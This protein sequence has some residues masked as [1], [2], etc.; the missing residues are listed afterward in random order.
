MTYVDAMRVLG[1]EGAPDSASVRRAYLARVKAHSPEKDP[2]GF[3]R[4]RS[5]F[6]LLRELVGVAAPAQT[7]EPVSG[8]MSID[9][10]DRTDPLLERPPP[11]DDPLDEVRARISACTDP[12]ER[13]RLGRE[14]AAVHR[15]AAAHWLWLES[16]DMEAGPDEAVQVAREALSHGH[17]EFL[18][19]LRAVHPS[20]LSDVELDAWLEEN[21][22]IPGGDALSLAWTLIDRR[23][24]HDASSVLQRLLDAG[25]G[26]LDPVATPGAILHL[27]LRLLE[28]GS[29]AEARG[30]VSALGARYGECPSAPGANP[31]VTQ[32]TIELAL[33]AEQ[34]DPALVKVI[35]SALAGHQPE[36]ADHVLRKVAAYDGPLARR[37]VAL[38]RT[39]APT[40]RGLY[41][42]PLKEGP[43]TVAEWVAS[44][45]RIRWPF[46]SAVAWGLY[47][48]VQ[49]VV[50][51]GHFTPA[52]TTAAARE[53]LAA[54]AVAHAPVAALCYGNESSDLCLAARS[55][56]AKRSCDDA[57][58]E[59]D[60]ISQLAERLSSHRAL[61]RT[62]QIAL[63]EIARRTRIQCSSTSTPASSQ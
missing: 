57:L 11:A 13:V 45:R 8:S 30:V 34:L 33:I 7:A 2:E 52:R 12:W 40:L 55:W 58:A 23:R 9:S 35:A 22:T 25:D 53:N 51:S 37:V 14:A 42:E 38:F 36:A 17:I 1:L 20:Q 63:A 44:L 56:Q 31:V 39:S 61:T 15:S 3:K 26:D 47:M 4:L 28:N 10:V 5:A 24:E 16:L 32:A 27:V 48:L 21:R 43:S 50:H 62:E 59:T 60:R 41:A 49:A 6:E 54:Q 29:L 18:T 46:G 19:W